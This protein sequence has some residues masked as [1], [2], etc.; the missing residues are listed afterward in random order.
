MP[1][2]TIGKLPRS[3]HITYI[4][5]TFGGD[6]PVWYRIGKDVEDMSVNLNPQT[7]TK[8]NIWDET[9]V[10][11]NGYEPQIDVDTYYAN[12]D[13][14]ANGAAMFY[15][16]LKNIAMNRLTGEACKTKYME[17]LIDKTTGAYD[18][19]V[20]DCVVK[21]TSYGGPQGGVA[22]P[23]TVYPD[24]NREQGTVTITDKV[25]TYTPNG[26]GDEDDSN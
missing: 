8:K 20:E 23:Y 11:D 15:A 6:T 10:E 14:P 2:T 9:T 26:S 21:P 17:V 3:A 13:D 12:P 1:E 24:G 7:E 19:W 18:A 25:P 16:K 4:D 22:I 5:A